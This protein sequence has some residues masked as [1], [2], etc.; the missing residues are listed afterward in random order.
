[1]LPRGSDVPLGAEFLR[2]GEKTGAAARQGKEAIARQAPS[3]GFEPV[4]LD[5]GGPCSVP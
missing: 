4:T 5:L 1:M 3:T 2:Q